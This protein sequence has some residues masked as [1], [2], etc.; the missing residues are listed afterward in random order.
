MSMFEALALERLQS[1]INHAL[2]LDPGTQ[3]TLKQLH[4]RHMEIHSTLPDLRLTISFLA[5]GQ[6]A[7]SSNRDGDADVILKGS[8]IALATLLAQAKSLVTFAETGVTVTGDQEILQRLGAILE[9]L[10]IDWEQAMAGVIGDLPAQFAGKAVRQAL[11]FNQ[12]AARRAATGLAEFIREESG[13][14]LSA[15]ESAQW[16]AQVTA[17]RH[18]TD[19]LSTRIQRLRAGFEQNN[20]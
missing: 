18:D 12:Q 9:Q 4:D 20:T 11:K 10:D 17:L 13:L 3:E 1:V 19:R 15:T 16:V 7:L 2:T 14:T 6:I 5:T 8:P